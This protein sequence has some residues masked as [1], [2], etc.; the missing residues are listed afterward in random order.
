[1]TVIAKRVALAR[2]VR[3]RAIMRKRVRIRH[4]AD[5][6]AGAAGRTEQE[7]EEPADQQGRGLLMAKAKATAKA[8]VGATDND[9]A[10][11]HHTNKGLTDKGRA[12]AFS[13]S[14]QATPPAFGEAA[15]LSSAPLHTDSSSGDSCV[16]ELTP[17]G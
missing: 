7:G 13:V 4:P 9:R 5:G 12:T 8:A 14:E 2:R 11:G 10:G 15:R 6:D 17:V 16:P 1:M 3:S